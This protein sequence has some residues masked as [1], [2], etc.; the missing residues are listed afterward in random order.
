MAVG[1]RNGRGGGKLTGNV[2]NT[3]DTTPLTSTENS[4]EKSPLV[5]AQ[6]LPQA[7]PKKSADLLVGAA[8][9]SLQERLSALKVNGLK[10]NEVEGNATHNPQPGMS[11]A[12]L[13]DHMAE[14]SASEKAGCS[15]NADD[16]GCWDTDDDDD[17]DTA[18]VDL[19][20][21]QFSFPI[22]LLIPIKWESELNPDVVEVLLKSVPASVSPELIR[23]MLTAVTLLKKGKAAFNKGVGFNGM[24]DPATGM[25][26][27]KVRGLVIEHQ[28][29]D[30]S[31]RHA[32]TDLSNTGR[33][34][35][36]H[37]PALTCDYCKGQHMTQYHNA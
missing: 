15:K 20:T 11:T 21:T 22:T 7:R 17:F 18:A 36:V 23:K 6:A 14:S 33:K 3:D 24:Q 31:W 29:D 25:D 34:L 4:P 8:K 26:T 30:D 27:D 5:S 1:R 32:V 35:M 12:L 19:L 16:D 28:N 9:I 37:Y 10:D 13:P 2:N